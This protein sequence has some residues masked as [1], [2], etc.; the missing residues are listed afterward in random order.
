MDDRPVKKDLCDQ[1]YLELKDDIKSLHNRLTE[2]KDEQSKKEDK[3]KES[4]NKQ[5][6]ELKIAINKINT[7]ANHIMLKIILILGAGLVGTI[8]YSFFLTVNK[9]GIP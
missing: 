2:Y 1:R 4:M 6:K 8:L 3:E 5:L 9:G 7:G